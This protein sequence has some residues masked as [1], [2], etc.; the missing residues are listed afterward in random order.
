LTSLFFADANAS[1]SFT[2]SPH[3]SVFFSFTESPGSRFVVFQLNHESLVGVHD[4]PR[5]FESTKRLV[6]FA[7]IRV[8]VRVCAC[9]LGQ[10][11]CESGQGALQLSIS[12]NAQ[13]EQI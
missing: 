9:E 1:F 5:S 13:A 10:G 11:A 8:R 6:L 7:C 3:P 4:W 2:E 12:Q